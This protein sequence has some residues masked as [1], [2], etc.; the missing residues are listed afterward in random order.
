MA[1]WA[2]KI[3]N[4][5]IIEVAIYMYYRYITFSSLLVE[6][7]SSSPRSFAITRSSPPDRL[8]CVPPVYAGGS[9]EC[10][11]GR[12]FAFRQRVVASRSFYCP[13]FFLRAFLFR[14]VGNLL[15]IFVLLFLY[16][17][18]GVLNPVSYIDGREILFLIQ[19]Q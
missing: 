5:C 15:G 9:V 2:C 6:P 4:F 7:I 17:L 8:R 16:F 14:F 11:P 3:M 1:V 10:G 18:V 13:R 19:S 12:V